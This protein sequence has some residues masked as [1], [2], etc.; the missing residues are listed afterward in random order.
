ME[1]E[2]IQSWISEVDCF[3]MSTVSI[4]VLHTKYSGQIEDV[5]AHLLQIQCV[6]IND[7]FKSQGTHEI[8]R[9]YPGI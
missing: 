5:Y 7:V 4:E 9:N 6:S 2:E 1:R 8:N 3:E